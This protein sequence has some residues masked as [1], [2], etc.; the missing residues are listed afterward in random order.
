MRVAIPIFGPRVSPR[1]DCAPSLLLFTVENGKVVERG[2]AYLTHLDLW[3][4]LG[5]LRELGIQALICGGIDGH[6]ARVLQDYQIQVISWVAGEADEAMKLFLQGELKSGSF[7]Y[8]RC[9]RKRY[10]N[11]KAK[12]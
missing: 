7:L 6:S 2:E 11:R 8:P 4:R 12:F 3:Q 1:F 5:R 10:R 9:G